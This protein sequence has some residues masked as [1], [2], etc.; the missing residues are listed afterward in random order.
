MVY[1]N[2]GV[3]G[4]YG[5]HHPPPPPPGAM[6]MEGEPGEEC[7]LFGCLFSWIPFVGIITFI[8]NFDAPPH[9]RRGFWARWALIIALVILISNIVFWPL[10]AY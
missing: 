10:M 3:Y 1:N 8:I 5:G 7:A 2:I 4:T 9:T 6:A